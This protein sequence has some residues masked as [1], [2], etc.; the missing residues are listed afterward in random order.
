[1]TTDSST[2]LLFD[3]LSKQLSLTKQLS[4]VSHANCL[5]FIDENG[6]HNLTDLQQLST[7]HHIIVISNR[8]DVA[9]KAKALHINTHFNDFDITDLLTTEKTINKNT[10]AKILA[11]R[12]SKEKPVTHHALNQLLTLVDHQSLLLISG[13]KND[14]IKSYTD[15][16]KKIFKLEGELK[17]HGDDYIAALRLPSRENAVQLITDDQK[18]NDSNY[19]H[20]RKITDIHFNRINH[21][22]AIFSKPG[23]FGWNKIDQGS[24]FLADTL[25]SYDKLN[26]NNETNLLDLGCGYGYLS[27]FAAS[28]GIQHITATDNNAA[29][30]LAITKTAAENNIKITIVADDCGASITQ[31]FD[32][33]FCN[34]P[35]HQ[36]FD[37]DSQLTEKFVNTAKNRLNRYGKAYFVT[38]A[39]IAIE[40]IAEKH[41]ASCKQ[42]ANNKKFK[43]LELTKM[44]PSN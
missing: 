32:I 5:I 31:T 39:F 36:G 13:K 15:K 10:D 27:I 28:L 30:I 22:Y 21:A 11:Y 24:L 25:S 40:K 1:M 29:A 7:H 9:K 41:F 37:I 35:F 2:R 44:Q 26:I 38:N 42:L 34:P 18:L 20:L 8:Y 14:G 6:V 23:V 33:I 12:V 43:V 17:K 3:E 4:K 19:T 16:I